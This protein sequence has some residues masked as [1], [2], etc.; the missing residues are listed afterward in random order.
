MNST[1]KHDAVPS[2]LLTVRAF[3]FPTG[4]QSQ[5]PAP[6][7]YYDEGAGIWRL[8]EDGTPLV[9]SELRELAR[10]TTKKFDIETGEDQK[11]Q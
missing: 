6:G 9:I 11:G 7:T 3:R 8:N 4:R 1:E 10:S 2:H 5:T